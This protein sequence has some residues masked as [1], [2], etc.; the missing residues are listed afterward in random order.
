MPVLVV[1]DNPTN[2]RILKEIMTTWRFEPVLAE[3]GKAALKAIEAAEESGKPF[4]LAMLDFMM[5]EMDGFELARRIRRD[6]D[7]EQLK[8]IILSSAIPSED[9]KQQQDIGI[10][11]CLTKP[12]LQSELLD[13]I[14]QVMGM[15]SE[16]ANVNVNE[17]P[18][19]P[20]LRVLVAED[21]I[22]NQ[23]VAVGMLQAGGHQAVVASDG[24]ETVAR[25]QSEPFDVILMDMHMPVMDGIEATEHI[26][27][28][29]Q[30]TD[31]HIPIIA[32]TAAAMK[33]DAESCQRAGMDAYLTK[34]IHPRMLQEMLARYAPERTT[35]MD[36]KAGREPG[37]S[38][39]VPGITTGSGERLSEKLAQS[40][41]VATQDTIDFR[42]AAGRVPGGLKG[43]R[44]LAEVF[45]PECNGLM[46]TL[47]AEIP[48][49]DLALVQR[50]AHTL[51]GSANLFSAKKVHDRAFDIEQTA[52]TGDL[53]PA[54]EQL[55]ILQQEVELMLRALDN[56]LEV[57]SDE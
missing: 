6:Y 2:L 40:K 28:A 4:S 5:P 36:A 24:R 48:A 15:K 29:E 47:A 19:C 16:L 55:G 22:A 3:D 57:T 27:A 43:V 34:P 8:L 9:L 56:F 37:T 46:K 21:G 7:S 25:W 23:H 10:S 13:T 12:V 26:R 20:P 33:E 45:I 14:L 18:S 50:T 49:G 44:R 30:G 42:A 52:K 32:L 39:V 38:F 11:R 53:E 1:D 31:N 17:L 54:V 51:K 41:L 35:L